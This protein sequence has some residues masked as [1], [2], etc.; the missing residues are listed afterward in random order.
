[1]KEFL[2]FS[3]TWCGPCKIL[4]PTMQQLSSEGMTVRKIDIDQDPNTPSQYNVR[5]VPTVILLQNGKEVSRQVGAQ[6]KDTYI[7]MWN[8]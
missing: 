5:S 4:A 8:M 7:N 1:M 6:P 3:A 2:Y